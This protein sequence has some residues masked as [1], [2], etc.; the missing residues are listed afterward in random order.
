MQFLC[1]VHITYKLAK[2]LKEL[3]HQAT[4]INLHLDKWH[5]KDNK[6]AEFANAH[7]YI[8]ISKDK[9]FRDSHFLKQLPKKLIKISLGNIS[10]N[11]LITIFQE[12]IQEID[13]VSQHEKF[14]IE[15]SPGF[16]SVTL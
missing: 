9:D 12:H 6:I 5:T 8:P 15:I 11:A 4:H 10:N 1:D 16:I 7:N 3:G 13:K 14:F 2:K